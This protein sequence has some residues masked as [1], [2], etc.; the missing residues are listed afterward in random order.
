MRTGFVPGAVVAASSQTFGI[1]PERGEIQRYD[2]EG[3]YI[4]KTARSSTFVVH[5]DDIELVPHTHGVETPDG[6]AACRGVQW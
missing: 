6:C 1:P 5:E 4:V 2:G 3:F